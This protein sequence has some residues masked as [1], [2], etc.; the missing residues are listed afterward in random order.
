M[1]LI[2]F[3]HIPVVTSCIHEFRSEFTYNSI[4]MEWNDMERTG[5]VE[6]LRML[7]EGN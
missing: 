7:V 1:L 6:I 3:S 5:W 4:K 2:P